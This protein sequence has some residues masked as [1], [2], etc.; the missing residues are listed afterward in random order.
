MSARQFS[1]RGPL[2]LTSRSL[3]VFSLDKR[4]LLEV[5]MRRHNERLYRT[6]RA[7]LKDEREA[8]DIMQQAY[9]KAY[10]HLRQFDGRAV[11]STWLTQIALKRSPTR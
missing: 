11:F 7:I 5:L 9:V 6:V 3:A 10:S 2:S 1:K 4:A 8:E